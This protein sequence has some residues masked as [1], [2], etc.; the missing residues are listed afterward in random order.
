VIEKHPE[1]PRDPNHPAKHIVG[2][3][4]GEIENREPPFAFVT[5]NRH[6]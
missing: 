3:A 6:D 2:I 4:T 1:R 5:V